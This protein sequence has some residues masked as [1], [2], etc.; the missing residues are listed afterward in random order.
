MDDLREQLANAAFPVPI[1]ITPSWFQELVNTPGSSLLDVPEWKDEAWRSSDEGG[2][3][4]KDFIHSPSASV[5]I[6]HYVMMSPHIPKIESSS[7]LVDMT[8][9]I[10]SKY[11]EVS[12]IKGEDN[13]IAETGSQASE[14]FPTLIG[15]AYFS[16]T[17][18]SHRGL[19][20][21]GSF[22]ALMDDVIGW[23]GFCVSGKVKPWSGYTVQ[24]NTA[25]CKAVKVGSI[26]RLE[27][28]VTKKEGSRKHWI[29]AKL[30]DPDTGVIHCKAEGL[31]LLSPEELS[32]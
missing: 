4:G 24:I 6:V 25:L 18:E 12:H 1:Q 23:M 31:F 9:G 13:S 19:C 29:N 21:G 26:M 22:C 28:W 20:H 17:A 5:R 7:S 16:R 15:L 32:Y 11:Q 3:A 30:W 27:A 14:T 8:E 10:S 2:F